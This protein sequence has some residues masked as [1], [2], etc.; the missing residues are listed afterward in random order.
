MKKIIILVLV[1]L[2]LSACGPKISG[3]L[4]TRE[5]VV[6]RAVEVIPP[7]EVFTEPEVN[8][9]IEQVFK[10]DKVEWS[11]D[12]NKNLVRIQHNADIVNF[13][14]K[15]GF[16]RK[17]SDT[18]KS[19]ELEYYDGFLSSASGD[20]ELPNKY[21]VENGLLASADDYN[22]AYDNDEKLLIFKEGVGVGTN[23]YYEDDKLDFT[24]KGNVAVHFYYND[25]GNLDHVE[26]GQNHFILAYGRGEKL[27]SL[28]GNMYGLGEMFDYGKARIS[29]ISNE[30]ESVF[31]GEEEALKKA[32][33]LYVSCTRFRKGYMVFEPIAFVMNNDYFDKS[34]YDYML[35]NFYC[36][37][38]P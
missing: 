8:E 17:I 10:T 1:L 22:F 33:D 18:K 24:K 27:A 32:F 5:K 31:Y 35:D 11:F 37:W 26:D 12:N 13:Y 6:Q 30:D 2:V 34:V 14:Y 23:F 19:V 36:E 7:K 28:S 15:D 25:K 29:V 38:L 9:T 21:V 3:E 4:K 20:T 16:L